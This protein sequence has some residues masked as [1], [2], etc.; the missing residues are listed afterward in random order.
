MKHKLENINDFFTPFIHIEELDGSNFYFDLHLHTYDSDSNIT[1]SN[2]ANFLKN[3]NYLVAVTD[4]NS[5][6]GLRELIDLG[7]NAVPGI[8]IGCSDGMEIIAYFKNYEDC[9]NF[10]TTHVLPYRDTKRM[11]RTSKD[12][13]FFLDVLKEFGAYTS[14]PHINGMAQKN[15]LK[16]KSYIFKVLEV[17][18]AVEIHN[19]GLSRKK[20]S[21][22]KEIKKLYNLQGTYGSD[23]HSMKEIESFYCYL[24]K[25]HNSMKK[26]VAYIYKIGVAGQ[27]GYKHLKYLITKNFI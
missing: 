24:N 6:G 4:H 26:V 1:P 25:T 18:D 8:E 9:K 16:N 11:A 27:I 3:K 17:V 23:A 5:I 22:A 2:L 13:W 19:F 14:I 20:N 15:F 10:Y 7:I 12:I 21:R